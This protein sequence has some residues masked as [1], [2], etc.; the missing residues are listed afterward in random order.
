MQSLFPR[1][2]GVKYS[3]LMLTPE[4]EYSITRRQ[5][6]DLIYKYMRSVLKTTLDK[7]ITDL[8]GNVGGDTILFGLKFGR[9]DSIE[10][11]RENFKALENNVKVFDLKNV[12]L[13]HGDSR[14]V[15]NWKTDV[16]YIDAPWGGPEYKTKTDIDL[17]LGNTRIDE[18]I[19]HML[20]WENSPDYFFL[21][22][23]K[24]Y[25]FARLT[26]L[27]LHKRRFPI[28]GYYLVALSKRPFTTTIKKTLRNKK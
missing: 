23:P 12:R 18:Y 13:H 7:H 11:D 28:R 17:Y 22:V 14:L 5:D 16:V 3:E 10:L 1:K 21:K 9:V 27:P 2:L 20:L 8:T 26:N 15:F 25:N 4:G 6:G 24:N 19:Q